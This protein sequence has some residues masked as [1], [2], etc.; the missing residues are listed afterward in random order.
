MAC[1]LFR[2]RGTSLLCEG[3]RPKWARRVLCLAGSLNPPGSCRYCRRFHKGAFRAPCRPIRSAQRRTPVLGSRIHSRAA[4]VWL[5]MVS[6][7][8]GIP[9]TL[10]CD[11][12]SSSL[13]AI[14]RCMLFS[15]YEAVVTLQPSNRREETDHRSL[16]RL[17]CVDHALDPSGQ[18]TWDVLMPS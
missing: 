6:L 7:H 17:P 13:A 10:R 15:R 16:V 18:V 12:N 4:V 9:F 2:S 11:Y 14:A 8:R 5:V 1:A 3:R